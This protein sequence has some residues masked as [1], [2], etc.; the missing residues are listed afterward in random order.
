MSLFTGGFKGASSVS[1]SQSINNGIMD[2]F[3][4]AQ[5]VEKLEAAA[6]ELV[7]VSWLFNA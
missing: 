4:I 5:L 6:N 1:S 2:A 3:E 7:A